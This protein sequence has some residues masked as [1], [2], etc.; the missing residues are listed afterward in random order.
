M[1]NIFQPLCKEITDFIQSQ[2]TQVELKSKAVNPRSL[3]S[4]KV[5]SIVFYVG[6]SN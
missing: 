2:I 4:V 3:E 1:K 6:K 5:N